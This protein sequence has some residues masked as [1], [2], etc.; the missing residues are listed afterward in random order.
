[1]ATAQATTTTRN[2]LRHW[3]FRLLILVGAGLMLYSWYSPWW[4]ARISDLSG[5]NHMIMR[6]WGVEV[7]V[8]EIRTYANRSLYSMP[9]YFAPLMW[10]YLGICM[11]ALAISLFVER[12][13]TLGR[14]RFSL[15]RLLVGLVGLSYVIAVGTA[16]AIAQIRAGDG[17]VQ[18]VGSSIVHNPMTGGNTRFTGELKLGY[19]LAAAA[20]LFLVVLALLRNVIVG[21]ART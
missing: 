1:M 6:P 4:G 21:R 10:A 9:D 11:L 17:G 16:F 18:F 13:I 20:G 19:W 2:S 12:R 15:P 7:M 3:L 14:F 8:A 5:D